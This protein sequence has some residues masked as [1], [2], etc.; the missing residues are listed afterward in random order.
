MESG[1][2]CGICLEEDGGDI[3]ALNCGHAFCNACWTAYLEDL[4]SKQTKESFNF[5]PPK[6]FCP[7]HK[8]QARIVEKKWLKARISKPLWKKYKKQLR[9]VCFV[10]PVEGLVERFYEIEHSKGAEEVRVATS[11]DFY[12]YNCCSEVC[13]HS[14]LIILKKLLA[15]W[16]RLGLC[17]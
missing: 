7:A 12:H 11:T 2:G 9:S 5:D 15:G 6:F 14:F 10:D 3:S 16:R 8:C 1:G 13:P 4:L 17:I